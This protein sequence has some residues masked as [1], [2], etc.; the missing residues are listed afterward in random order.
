MVPKLGKFI[1]NKTA[2]QAKQ[3]DGTIGNEWLV[4]NPKEEID[5]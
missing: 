5:N 2:K 4:E 1:I 3:V